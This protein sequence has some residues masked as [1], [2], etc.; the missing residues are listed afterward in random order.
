MP[1][2]LVIKWSFTLLKCHVL[3]ATR[4]RLPPIEQRFRYSLNGTALE[5]H[6]TEKDLGVLVTTKLSWTEHCNKLCSVASSRL[7][8]NMRTCHFIQNTMQKRTLYLAL[9]RSQFEHCSIVWRPHT[10]TSKTKIEN[11]QKRAV[12]WILNEIN[13]SYTKYSYILKCKQLDIL[14][15]NSHFLVT[16]LVTFH[17]IFYG[18]SPINFPHYLKQFC[19]NTRLRSCHLDQLSMVSTIRPETL[20]QKSGGMSDYQALEHCY[21]YRTHTAWNN[22]PLELREIVPPSIFKLKLKKHIWKEIWIKLLHEAHEEFLS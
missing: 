6:D 22:L 7:G 16:D 20:V 1:G 17:Q 12:K 18:T 11:I 3:P 10:E 4:G 2:Q 21:F 5:Y 14:P 9:V 8:L 13:A 15:L 19:G